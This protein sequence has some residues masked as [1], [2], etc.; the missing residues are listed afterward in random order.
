MLFVED[1]SLHKRSVKLE[2]MFDI[3]I[4]EHQWGWSDVDIKNH[5]LVRVK[6]QSCY[7]FSRQYQLLISIFQ[8]WNMTGTEVTSRCPCCWHLFL[9][10]CC[11]PAATWYLFIGRHNKKAIP[12]IQDWIKIRYWL[13]INLVKVVTVIKRSKNYVPY[14]KNSFLKFV[15]YIFSILL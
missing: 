7:T 15:Y 8:A 1:N 6:F 14:P 10:C 9:Y 4:P 3:W 5:G 2:T 12:A 11:L 13:L